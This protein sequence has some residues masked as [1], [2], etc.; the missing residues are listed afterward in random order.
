MYRTTCIAALAALMICAP[1]V[2][3]EVAEDPKEPSLALYLDR[4]QDG[5]DEADATRASTDWDGLLNM[6]YT[7]E[8]LARIAEAI[9]EDCTFISFRT[10]AMSLARELKIEAQGEEEE[11]IDP[12]DPMNAG[13][14]WEDADVKYLQDMLVWNVATSAYGGVET[15][16]DIVL[17]V[18]GSQRLD[19]GTPEDLVEPM[20]TIR[21]LHV[22]KSAVSLGRN[23]PAVFAIGL[24]RGAQTEEEFVWRTRGPAWVSSGMTIGLAVLSVV[25]DQEVQAA[26]GTLDNPDSPLDDWLFAA[27]AWNV[28]GAIGWTFVSVTNIISN[29]VVMDE[30]WDDRPGQDGKGGSSFRLEI[31]VTPQSVW[32]QGRF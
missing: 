25:T 22:I 23:V 32:V 8:D 29:I 7:A 26:R 17:A 24:S 11:E 20:T 31:A 4:C 28:A 13:R 18:Q 12:D 6:G 2:A 5:G 1:A 19:D 21:D 15:I 10:A 14:S 16:A 27:H 9:P 3:E 30:Y